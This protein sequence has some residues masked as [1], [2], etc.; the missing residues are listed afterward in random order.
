MPI[1]SERANRTANSVSD[2]IVLRA[3][4]TTAAMH[5]L[6]ALSYVISL[7]YSCRRDAQISLRWNGRV[8]CISEIC[9]QVQRRLSE[10]ALLY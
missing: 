9:F 1:R 3:C 2:E 7:Q 4:A 6:L 8:F 10:H 5:R